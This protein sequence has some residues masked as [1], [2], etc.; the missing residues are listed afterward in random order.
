MLTFNYQIVDKSLKPWYLSINRPL[1]FVFTNNK[2]FHIL[3]CCID[4]L[5]LKIYWVICTAYKQKVLDYKL[6]ENYS[7]NV[8][9]DYN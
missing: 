7:V 3:N 9:Y 8:F 4:E 6:S 2:I 5:L 1:L